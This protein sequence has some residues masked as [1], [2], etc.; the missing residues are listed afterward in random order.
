MD[1]SLRGA[2]N[3]YE[4]G[5]LPPDPCCLVLAMVEAADLTQQTLT[6]QEYYAKTHAV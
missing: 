4:P 6:N 2:T 5:I 3:S 1:L